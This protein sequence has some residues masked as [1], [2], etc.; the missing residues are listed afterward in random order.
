MKLFEK[1]NILNGQNS[2]Y[3]EKKRDRLGSYM[4]PHTND[5]I[6]LPVSIQFYRLPNALAHM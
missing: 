3:T 2:C 1:K 6:I 5:T 4:N